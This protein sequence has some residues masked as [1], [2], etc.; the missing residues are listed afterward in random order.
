MERLIKDAN[1]WGAANGKASDL[2][3]ESFSDVVTAIQQIQEKQQIAG[4]T[5]REAMGTI[6]GSFNMLHGAWENLMSGFANPD[7]NLDKL[8]DNVVTAGTAVM[9]NLT[10]VIERALVG[11]GTMLEKI[12]PIISEKLPETLESVL[13]KLLT[14]ATTLITTLMDSIPSLIASTAPTIVSAF[15]IVLD[16]LT[17]VTQEFFAK[18]PEWVSEIDWGELGEI[19]GKLS[20]ALLSASESLL[21]TG[22]ILMQNVADGMS[23]FDWTSAASNIATWLTSALTSDEVDTFISAGTSILSSIVDG[24]GQ[25][26]EVLAPTGAEIITSITASLID[27]ADSLIQS[28]LNLIVNITEGMM[29]G[30]IRLLECIPQIIVA[31]VGAIL[32]NAPQIFATVVQVAALSV[33]RV[34]ETLPTL[35]SGVANLFAQLITL[36]ATQGSSIVQNAVNVAVTTVTGIVNAVLTLP[37]K[38][39]YW[40][41]RAVAMFITSFGDLPT[42]AKPILTDVLNKVIEFGKD[43]VKQAPEMAKKFV[44][45]LPG[46]LKSLPGKMKEVGKKVVDGLKQGVANAWST[47]ISWI[48][49]KAASLVKSFWEGF[50]NG[51]KEKGDSGSGSK[52]SAKS[53]SSIVNTAKVES[54][55]SAV[56]QSKKEN[57]R[58]EDNG[59]DYDKLATAV[60]KA[61]GQSDF[62]MEIDGREFGRVVRKAVAY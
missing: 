26:Y 27:N 16:S 57:A 23:T 29:N 22:L 49:E 5:A 41:G 12:A 55:L 21:D 10:P 42:K 4:T 20:E 14:A 39:A 43:F 2:T 62:S 28:G 61:F 60:A 30:Q 56:S 1:E 34:L 13:P 45:E 25:A 8:I 59:I 7:L 35:I 33:Q 54:V 51:A 6:E 9:S 40:A 15:E 11:I 48:K 58:E 46:N 24:M 52:S 32:R 47:F 44:K 50:K 36:I 37:N 17:T 18:I 53:V 3:I 38:I 31:I 19:G